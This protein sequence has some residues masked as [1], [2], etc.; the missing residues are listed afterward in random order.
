VSGALP[1]A[2]VRFR[3]VPP[4]TGAQAQE[5]NDVTDDEILDR[6]AAAIDAGEDVRMTR[7]A[8]V[9]RWCGERDVID[10]LSLAECVGALLREVA[11]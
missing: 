8:A 4:L 1:A 7:A 5:V 6:E 11:A 3:G 9:G 10:A 2:A